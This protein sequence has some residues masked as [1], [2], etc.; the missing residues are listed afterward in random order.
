MIRRRAA[1]AAITAKLGNHSC[2]ASGITAYLKSRTAARWRSAAQMANHASPRTTQLH[3]RRREEFGL[4]EVEKVQVSVF[5]C[6]MA[7]CR[8]SVKA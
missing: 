1:A 4:D 7:A 3:D 8:S 6:I 5:A 2:H